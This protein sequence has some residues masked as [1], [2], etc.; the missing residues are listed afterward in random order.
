MNSL[1]TT[2]IQHTQD[3]RCMRIETSLGKDAL[4]LRR[5]RATEGFSQLFN[6][7]VDLLSYEENIKADAIVG[8][9]A[10]IFIGND[11]YEPRFLNG[12]VK[13]FVYTGLERRGLYGY[14]AELVPWLWFLDKRTNCR[15]FQNQTVQQIIEFILKELGFN[16]FLFSLGEAHAPLEY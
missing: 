14:K 8:E 7:E 12:F 2:D 6:I 16:D 4:L 9:H 11:G 15:V 13:S 1:F 5:L 3:N 10:A